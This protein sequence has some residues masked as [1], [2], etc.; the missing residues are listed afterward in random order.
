MSGGRMA[1]FL[2]TARAFIKRDLAIAAS[3]R[4]NVVL[5]AI[6]VG[7][8]IALLYFV[9]K[10][11]RAEGQ[12]GEFGGYFPFAVVGLASLSLLDA[13][14]ASVAVGLR[15]EQS[16]GTLEELLL[17]RT[18]PAEL[19]LGGAAFSFAR[20]CLTALLYF[21]A[22]AVVDGWFLHGNALLALAIV[23]L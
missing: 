1:G 15:A 17:S 13:A 2:R 5:Q 8:L 10:L 12:L 21:V 22:A 7:V 6:S 20:A 18:G 23:A 3:Y 9:A 4:F 19:L 14:Y 11:V 16:V